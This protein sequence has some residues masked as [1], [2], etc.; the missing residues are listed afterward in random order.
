MVAQ[1]NRHGNPPTEY[2]LLADTPLDLRALLVGA[3]TERRPVAVT[4]TS[5][6]GAVSS[7]IGQ[8]VTVTA[9]QLTLATP[10]GGRARIPLWQIDRAAVI[11]ETEAVA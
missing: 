10:D 5:D 7:R 4:E 3:L 2:R 8:P 1:M 6:D 9:E 11:D